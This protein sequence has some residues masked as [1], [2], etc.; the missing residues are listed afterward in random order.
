MKLKILIDESIITTEFFS[1]TIGI[2]TAQSFC[3]ARLFLA[4][5]EEDAVVNVL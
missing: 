3:D 4:A 2:L 5:D 1:I